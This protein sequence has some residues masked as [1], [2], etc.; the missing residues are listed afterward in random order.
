MS[1]PGVVATCSPPPAGPF[2]K[3]SSQPVVAEQVT[4]MSNAQFGEQYGQAL[5]QYLVA[6]GD[7]LQALIKLSWKSEVTKFVNALQQFRVLN[8]QIA[9][10]SR[11][12]NLVSNTLK[13]KHDAAKNAL[14]N[15]RQQ[16]RGIRSWLACRPRGSGAGLAGIRLGVY[17][18]SRQRL[19]RR[20]LDAW[21]NRFGPRPPTVGTSSSL[22]QRHQG[23]APFDLG[24]STNASPLARSPVGS[25]GRP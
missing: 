25:E 4:Q 1:S 7:L 17:G 21:A 8:E 3:P 6:Q 11:Q 9:V 18:A 13:A 14:H 12:F 5:R 10:D 22:P 20:R 15:V 16:Q 19:H 24:S 2:F 23:L